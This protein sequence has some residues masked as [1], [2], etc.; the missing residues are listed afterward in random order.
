MLSKVDEYKN[1]ARTLEEVE[2]GTLEWA[3]AL[4]KTNEQVMSLI[5]SYPMLANYMTMGENGAL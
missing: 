1:A 5:R 2:Q 3:E 4:K